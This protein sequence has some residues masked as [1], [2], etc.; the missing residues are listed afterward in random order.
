MHAFTLTRSLLFS[1]SL[2]LSPILSLI[3]SLTISHAHTG[4]YILILNSTLSLSRTHTRSLTCVLLH[5]YT[6]VHTH[7]HTHILTHTYSHTPPYKHVR[8]HSHTKSHQSHTYTFI[9]TTR[10][11]GQGNHGDGLHGSGGR[12]RHHN[13]RRSHFDTLARSPTKSHRYS[14]S[15]GLSGGSGT[16][17]ACTRRCGGCV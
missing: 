4:L 16:F 7:T 10:R 8:T 15:C 13:Q 3:L 9:Y 12:E 5:T 2:S 11:C 1:Y 14:W 17:G 6:I